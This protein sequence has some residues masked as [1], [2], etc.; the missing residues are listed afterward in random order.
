MRIKSYSKSIF[1]VAV[2]FSGIASPIF[3]QDE[4]LVTGQVTAAGDDRET[5]VGANIVIKG[6]TKG[7][8]TD[9]EGN[10]SLSVPPGSRLVFSSIGYLPEEVEVNHQT[11]IDITMQ[12]DVKSLEEI[13]IIGYGEQKKKDIT[14]SIS[15]ISQAEIANQPAASIDNLLQG[16]AAG[17]QISQSS[18]APGGRTNIRIRGASSINAGNE[19]LFVID[20]I[21]VYNNSKDP[22]GTSYGTFTPT[23]ALASLNPNDIES[24]EILKDASATAIYGSRGSNGVIIIT[25]KRGKGDTPRIAYNGYYGVQTLHSKIDLMDG[26]EHGQYLNDWA[27]A[28]ALLQPFADPEAIGKGTDWQEE[29]FR[30]ASIQN[31][32]LSVSSGKGNTQYF[33]SGNYFDQKGIA[34][35]SDLKRYS[36]RI[37]VDNQLSE[38]LKFSQSLTFNRTVNRSVPTSSAGSSNIRSVVDK[39]FATS[40][41]IA[42]YDENGDY[43]EEWYGAGKP[44]NPVAALETIRNELTGDNLLGNIGLSYEIAKG[45]TFKTMGGVNLINRANEEYYPRETTY[46][47]GLL[48][49]LGLISNR[50]ITNILN[51]NTLRFSR[52][53]NDKHDI[54][55]LGGF[56]W[57]TERNEHS[58]MQPSNFPDD[59]FGV[60]NTAGSTGVPEIASS[61]TAWSL[62]SWLGRANYQFNNKYLLTATF[63]ADGSSK[64]GKGNKWGF[65]PS[66]AVGYRLSEEGFIQSLDL[67]DDLKLRGSYGVTGNQEIGS[68]Q[69]LARLVTSNIYIFDD[70]LVA[71]ASQTSLANQNLKWE[72]SRQWDIGLDV[73]MLKN[74]LRL[75]VDYYHKDTEDLLFTI[76]LPGYS[77]YSTALYNTGG[78]ENRGIEVGIGADILEG[79]FTWT[80]DANYARNRSEITSLGRSA[81]TSLFVGY[82]PGVIRG[83]VY[84]GVFQSQAEIDAQT[85][86]LGVEPGD[87]RYR[88]TNDDGL[89]DADDRIIL[90]DPLPDHIFGVS[91]RFTFKGLSL[92]VFLQGELGMDDINDLVILNP[93]SGS[94][95]KHRSLLDRWTPDNPTNDIPRAGV[96][97]WLSNSTY[98]FQDRSYIKIRNIRLGY[99]FPAN[100]LSWLQNASIYISGQNLVTST[101][102]VGYD[103]DGGRH[104]P[105]AKTVILGFNLGF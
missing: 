6:T 85:V 72:K 99:S 98:A 3:A 95:N 43:V 35:N 94:S 32:Q 12:P 36:I 63:R 91:N 37:N 56:T 71:G 15:S 97:N 78:L 13:V 77:G 92:D 65:F 62:A 41:T 89:I 52:L 8:V 39:V 30:T 25:T 14:G 26:A 51:E 100:A 104:Y 83:Y 105:T 24:V 88:D 23:N 80:L 48:G 67:F 54:E 84:D 61:V 18:G 34:L 4:I 69:S 45:L 70:Q 87:A 93:S 7:T 49:G 44:E 53:I 74:R 66:L 16:R 64:F 47:G 9:V 81:S 103:P 28:N 50:R 57:Q 42:V 102:Y 19:P 59:R 27:A 5:L 55:V 75:V 68:Y 101:D 73:A 79:A 60:N 21:P 11:R 76:N 22:G 33:I 2:F 31:H 82:P 10:Y 58:S 29:I 40:P 96:D 86:Q 17:I 20:G 38:R 1:L 90:G 46:I